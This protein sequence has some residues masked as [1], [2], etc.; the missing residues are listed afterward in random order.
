MA[1]QKISELKDQLAQEKPYLE[2][3]E[4]RGGM[5]FA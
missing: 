4:I 2:E 1:Y 5:N 3:D